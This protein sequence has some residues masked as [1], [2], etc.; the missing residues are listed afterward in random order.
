MPPPVPRWPC[1]RLVSPE[2]LRQ[3]EAAW[4]ARWQALCLRF[5]DVRLE[6]V[7][8]RGQ[9]PVGERGHRRI[10][11]TSNLTKFGQW[12]ARSRF[13]GGAGEPSSLR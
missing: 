4:L 11:K 3:Q 8:G 1:R 9:G 2:D 10:G 12:V 5:S 7:A 13:V 6:V